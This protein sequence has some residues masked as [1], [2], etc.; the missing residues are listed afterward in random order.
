[1]EIKKYYNGEKL[2]IVINGRID[3]VTS[4][5]LEKALS[6]IPSHVNVL[7][8]DFEYVEYISSACLRV[9]LM[10][11]KRLG[12]K[13]SITIANV[14]KIVKEVFSITGFDKFIEVIEK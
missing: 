10:A 1:M 11:K 2:T 9:L 5:E 7:V 13:G 8:F 4:P 14:N 6:D 3:T 12:N